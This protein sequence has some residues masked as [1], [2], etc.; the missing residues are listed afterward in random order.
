[1]CLGPRLVGS[2]DVPCGLVI[3]FSP[4]AF[5]NFTLGKSDKIKTGEDDKISIFGAL[6]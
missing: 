5:L 1:M 6:S 2:M 3:L 4:V